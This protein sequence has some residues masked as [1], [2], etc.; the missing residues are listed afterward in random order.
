MQELLRYLNFKPRKVS[1]EEWHN[2]RKDKITL[3]LFHEIV[4]EV[5]DRL[6]D[7][8]PSSANESVPFVHQR[9]GYKQLV[10]VIMD[11]KPLAIRNE[12]A[13]EL[14]DDD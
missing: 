11:W 3:E 10:D 12:K 6:S 5:F 13:E 8:P 4:G 7:P 1:P 14:S 9:E 2:W